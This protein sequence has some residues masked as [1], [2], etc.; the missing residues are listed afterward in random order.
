MESAA[1]RRGSKRRTVCEIGVE[2]GC[3]ESDEISRSNATESLSCGDLGM[4][5]RIAGGM[6]DLLVRGFKPLRRLLTCLQ[7]Y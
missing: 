7:H 1:G 4:D 2:R 6:H 5:R 3:V